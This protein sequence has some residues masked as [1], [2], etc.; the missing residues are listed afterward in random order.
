VI[1]PPGFAAARRLFAFRICPVSGVVMRNG[2]RGVIAMDAPT[3]EQLAVLAQV[4]AQVA[5]TGRLSPEDGEDFAQFVQ[6]RMIERQ[7]EVFARFGGRSSLHTYLKVVVR[8]LLLDWRNATRGKW[9]PSAA[10][11]RLGPAAVRMERLVYRDGM[12]PHE[13]VAVLEGCGEGDPVTLAALLEQVPYRPPRRR[14]PDDAAKQLAA[15]PFVDPVEIE[16][17]RRARRRMRSIL[18]TAIS[19]LPPEEQLLIRSRYYHTQSIQDVARALAVEPKALYRRVD[20]A[21]RSLRRSLHGAGINGFE[22]TER[23]CAEAR[24]TAEFES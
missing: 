10:A 9:R 23:T 24:L 1:L 3:P 5:R 14:V 13:A 15:L 19:Q 12:L 22:G 17:A 8:R 2:Q 7:Y 18:A 11:R 4:T 21:L 6:L 20:R 16:Q